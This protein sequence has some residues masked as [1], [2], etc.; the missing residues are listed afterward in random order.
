MFDGSPIAH[1]RHHEQ[2]MT[3]LPPDPETSLERLALTLLEETRRGSVKWRR[4]GELVRTSNAG[5]VVTLTSLSGDAR[6]TYALTLT[7]KGKLIGELRWT[8][9][10][11]TRG[12]AL[13]EL[14]ALAA[15]YATTIDGDVD[16]FLAG[17]TRPST[18]RK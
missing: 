15:R 7:V 3:A 18:R 6:A 5:G 1:R 8:E 12:G 16:R 4:E 9:G 11:E 14:Y 17:L 10:D 13:K 2:Q